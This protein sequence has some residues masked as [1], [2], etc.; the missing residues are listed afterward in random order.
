MAGQPLILNLISLPIAAMII[1]KLGPVGYGQWA[2][3]ASLL[4]F[5]S[6]ATN[7]GLRPIFV[8]TVAQD[9]AKA[10]TALAVQLS[11]RATLAA[12]AGLAAVLLCLA[13]GY[14]VV[15]LKCVAVS[16][17]GLVAITACTT[18]ADLL[19]GLEELRVYAATSFVA[20]IVVS[21]AQVAAMLAGFGPV[22]LSVAY[23]AAPATSLLLLLVYTTRRHFP[24]RLK[25]HLSEHRS[26]LKESGLLGFHQI[27]MAARNR[28]EQ[29]LLPKLVGISGMGYFTA[30]GMLADRLAVVPD[31]FATAFYPSVAK[32]SREDP[33]RSARCVGQFVVASFAM[34]VPI[35]VI[36]AFLSNPIARILFPGK[37]QTCATVMQITIWCI[38]LLGLLSPLSYS[39]QAIGKQNVS[40][41][42]GLQTTVVSTVL[43]IGLTMKFGVIG[44]AWSTVLRYIIWTFFLLPPFLRWFPAVPRLVPCGRIIGG[45]ILM[46]GSIAACS[47]LPIHSA[48]T[49]CIST[50][51]GIAVYFGTLF[52]TRVVSPTTVRQLLNRT[53]APSTSSK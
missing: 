8:R 2:V 32:S 27:M 41:A 18:L 46:G 45:A 31:G 22:G 37:A 47:L 4:A 19:Q 29:L 49:L 28:L 1:R 13:L 33:E 48:L 52:A 7:L 17:I 15:I 9:P 42:A 35:A 24:V 53:P 43:A 30:G 36:I 23:L 3:A 16:G 34:C 5:T 25:W 12:G 14:P 26:M 44:A 39:L 11:L 51:V 50:A 38:P 21:A 20:G 6:I 10:D 40:A